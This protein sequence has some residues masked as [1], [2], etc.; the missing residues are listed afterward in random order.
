MRLL[1]PG[2]FEPSMQF[3]YSVFS[4]KIPFA[5][6]Y[7]RSAEQPTMENGSLEL[8]HGNGSFFVKGK[9]KWNTLNI[10]CYQFENITINDF[11]NYANQHQFIEDAKDFK[12]R[13]YKHDLR[14][15]ILSPDEIPT[16]TW[17]LVGAFFESVSFGQMDRGSDDVTEID[18]TIRF[19]YAEYKPFI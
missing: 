7:A 1:I 8:H 13:F 6:F 5:F 16:G 10:K 18:L 3:R 2:V 17:K 14:L 9:T 19:D 12:A 15:S 4:T 11:W